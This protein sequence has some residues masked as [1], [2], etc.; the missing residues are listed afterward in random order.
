MRNLFFCFCMIAL[1][2]ASAYSADAT[3]TFNSDL[4][5]WNSPASTWNSPLVHS[6]TAGY[7]ASGALQLTDADVWYGCRNTVTIGAGDPNY[8]LQAWA[9]IV[10]IDASYSL[11]LNTYNLDKDTPGGTSIAFATDTLMVWQMQQQT[12]T[13]ASSIGTGYIMINSNAPWA[14]SDPAAEQFFLDDVSYTET[15][16]V[17]DWALY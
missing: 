12:G 6:S 14:A 8:D 5:G 10:V 2:A 13:A 3:W 16:N 7:T 9:Y 1:L 15:A 4:E 11:G 17:R